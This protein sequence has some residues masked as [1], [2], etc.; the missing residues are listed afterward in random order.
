MD[1]DLKSPVRQTQSYLRHLFEERGLRPKSKLGQ[2]FL[3]DLNL[4][5]FIVKH[6]ELSREDM[7]LEVGTGTGSLTAA[8]ADQAGAVL[9]VEIDAAFHTLVQ[10]ALGHHA[11][12]RFF[13]GDVLKNKNQLNPVMLETL[14][15][16]LARFEG[17]RLKLVAN[18]PYAVATPVISNLILSELSLERMVVTVQWEIAQRLTAGPGAKEYGALAILMQ[19]LAEI[20]LLRKLPASVF[21]PRPRVGSAIVRIRPSADKRSQ[22]PDPLRFRHFLRDLYAHRRKNLRGGLLSLPG[23]CWDKAAVDRNLTG[24]GV[25]GGCRAE[26]LDVSTH[27][28][29]CE[30]FG[31]GNPDPDM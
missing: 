23:H 19:S 20:D 13:H 10:E 7:V 21:W 17:R 11:H 3:V 25:D 29:L 1:N 28:R 9:S 6:A 22:V 5:D 30:T 18:L 24:L 26:T 27:L 8:L 31:G 2:N 14:R 12:V 15:A 4:I 16:G